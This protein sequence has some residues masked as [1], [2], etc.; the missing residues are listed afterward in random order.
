M[1]KVI[2]FIAWL[3]SLLPLR[4]LYLLA[5]IGFVLVFYVA[6]YRRRLV[7]TNLAKCFP[8]KDK[9]ERHEIERRFYHHFCNIFVETIKTISMSE[10]EMARRFVFENGEILDR[11]YEQG[12]SLIITLGHFGNWEWITFAQMAR[13]PLHP[14]FKSYSVYHELEGSAMDK[15]YLRLRSRSKSVLVPRDKLLRALVQQRK[16]GEPAMFCFIADQGPLN[17]AITFW[18]KW[19]NRETAPIIGPEKIARQT[20]FDILYIDVEVVRKGYYKARFVP[21]PLGER[22]Y[23]FTRDYMRH[24]EQTILRKPEY[25]L[26]SH[27]RWKRHRKG[28]EELMRSRGLENKI[29][30]AALLDQDIDNAIP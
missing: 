19:L 16:T 21:L 22:P 6:R 30:E 27:N 1:D 20:G 26:W 23:D 25:W 13:K 11:Y 29:Q 17:E 7:R 12:K 28:W 24:M 15:F 3:F 14:E 2:Y 18:M 10:E 4:A 9:R 5:D 8:D